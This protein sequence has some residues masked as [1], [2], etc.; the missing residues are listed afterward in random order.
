[1]LS[2]SRYLKKLLNMYEIGLFTPCHKSKH[3]I[4]AS[5]LV[6]TIWPNELFA[7]VSIPAG[8]LAPGIELHN[9]SNKMGL[10]HKDFK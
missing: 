8:K 6:T 10:G 1:M 4:A 3:L 2:G 9:K 5:I 7:T